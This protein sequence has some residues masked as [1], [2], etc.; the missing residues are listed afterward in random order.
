MSVPKVFG[1]MSA[2]QQ[3]VMKWVSVSSVCSCGTF[4]ARSV[5]KN[6]GMTMT[7]SEIGIRLFVVMLCSM[8]LF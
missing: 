7:C 4:S 1:R 2:W 8:P 5:Q 3:C 6:A